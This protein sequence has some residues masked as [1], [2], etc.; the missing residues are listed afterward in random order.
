[1]DQADSKLTKVS[2]HEVL[3]EDCNT[4]QVVCI[5]T[6]LI[7]EKMSMDDLDD[8]PQSS[9]TSSKRP[10]VTSTVT[11]FLPT[12]NMDLVRLLYKQC[13]KYDQLV[14]VMLNAI[15]YLTNDIARQLT[16]KKENFKNDPNYLNMFVII[17]EN[18]A[19]HSPEALEKIFPSFCQVLS[20]LPVPAQAALAKYWSKFGE[21]QLRNIMENVQ[22]LITFKVKLRIRSNY[23][24]HKLRFQFFSAR[25]WML[26]ALC[27]SG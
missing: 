22:Q 24:Y 7:N 17:M 18:P 3:T 12:V 14:T 20:R 21:T 25:S 13:A 8:E 10:E 4:D 27:D 15:A 5:S 19:I 16:A 6:K 26:N 1:M 11:V 23:H 2:N 9:A